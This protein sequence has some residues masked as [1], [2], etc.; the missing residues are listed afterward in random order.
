MKQIQK[1]DKNLYKL[2]LGSFP[3]PCVDIVVECKEKFLFLKRTE[4]PAQGE[5]WFPGGRLYK[6]E[7]LEDCIKR[8]LN[9]EVGIG[10]YKLIDQIGAF[11]TIF[12]DGPFES[13]S[14][15][16]NVTYHVIVD[17]EEI[18]KND[19]FFDDYKWIYKDDEIILKH[20]Y[21]EYISG[22]LDWVL[23]P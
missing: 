22:I 6:N 3:I 18:K 9:E 8:K 14:H 15:T 1:V 16:I 4:K 17:S 12:D 7:T 20:N 23:L 10:S 5:Y 11:E 19:K 13:Q 2:M 21:N